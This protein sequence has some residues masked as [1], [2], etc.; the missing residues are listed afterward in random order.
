MPQHNAKETWQVLLVVIKILGVITP[1]WQEKFKC[2][3]FSC[4]E[5]IWSK[6]R[7]KY[8]KFKT[9]WWPIFRKLQ[10]PL[11]ILQSLYLKLSLVGSW[12][13]AE[14]RDLRFKEWYDQYIISIYWSAATACSV[15]YG[16]IHAH[17]VG[18]KALSAFIMIG[19]VVFFGYIIA[20]VTASLANAD[21]SRA[22]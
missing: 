10:K 1:T 3:P 17:L 2:P 8:V 9:L 13:R 6:K 5:F 19:G 14:G 21:A 18:E 12:A 20:S 4:F 15:G 7:R 16:D 22:M 11:D